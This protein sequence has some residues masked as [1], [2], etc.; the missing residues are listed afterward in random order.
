M[1][2]DQDAHVPSEYDTVDA[3]LAEVDYV[4]VAQRHEAEKRGEPPPP[5]GALGAYDGER[6]RRRGARS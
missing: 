1:A 6:F 2:W 5:W 4:Y 3:P